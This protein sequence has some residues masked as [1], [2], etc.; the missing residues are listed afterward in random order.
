MKAEQQ[1]QAESLY[2]QT[3][4][5]KTEIARIIGISRRTVHYWVRHNH[6]DRIRESAQVMPV[7]LAGNCYCI[8]AKL[9]ESILSPDRAGKPVTLQE[10]NAMHRL[11]MTI[12]KLKDR[13]TLNENVEM[14]TYFMD[15]VHKADP[16]MAEELKPVI[17]NYIK[18]RAGA[19]ALPDMTA[20]AHA[21]INEDP[22]EA[23]LDLE[24]LAS[25][26]KDN[27]K[28]I[29]AVDPAPAQTATKPAA[30]QARKQDTNVAI[31][32]KPEVAG[33]VSKVPPAHSRDVKHTNRAARRLAA[34]MA[35]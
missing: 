34:R 13:A 3:S 10:V 28:A 16:A 12:S 9:Q 25:W 29:D 1:K 8:L 31:H 11:T 23:R 6:W 4:L 20:M 18:S 33:T 2:F 35:A 7:A 22:S 27:N 21:P 15:F 30:P 19:Q 32:G 14:M 5:T 26:E 17:N 24:D